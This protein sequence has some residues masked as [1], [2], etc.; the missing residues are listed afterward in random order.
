MRVVG[1]PVDRGAARRFLA[2]HVP[3]VSLSSQEAAAEVEI[4]F[5]PGEGRF[6]G[7]AQC[8]VLVVLDAAANLRRLAGRRWQ[9]VARRPHRILCDDSAM[10]ASRNGC[11]FSTSDAARLFDAIT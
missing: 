3:H 1:A 5:A 2:A 8:N 9:S 4:L 11:V 7:S 6:T 10:A